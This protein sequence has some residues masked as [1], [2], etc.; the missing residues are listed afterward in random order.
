MRPSDCS[1]R[2]MRRSMAS[3]WAKAFMAAILQFCMRPM[4]IG[5]PSLQKSCA[6]ATLQSRDAL[7]RTKAHPTHGARHAIHPLGQPDGHRRLRVRRIRGARPRRAGA[8]VQDHGLHGHRQ[9]PHQERHAVPAGRGQLHH[10]RRAELLCAALRAP[11]WPQRVR[12]GL[13]CAGRACRLRAR[14]RTRRLGLRPSHRSDGA[15]HPGH[16]GH[17]RFA[18]LLRRPLARQGRRANRAPSATSASTTSTSCPSKAR[19]P[20]PQATA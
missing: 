8:I 17:R 3:S 2:R 19:W 4:S 11:A 12:D 16:Q 9:A 1:A 15:Q 10:Q 14:A 13:S 18:D 7:T 5:P 20:R 6:F